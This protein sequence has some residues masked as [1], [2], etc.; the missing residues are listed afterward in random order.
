MKT[1][2]IGATGNVGSKVVQGLVA[3]GVNVR[4]MTRNADKAKGTMPGNVEIMTGDLTDPMTA[5]ACFEGCDAVFMLNPVAM[6][7]C[8]EGL[9]GVCLAQAAGVKK[10]VYM[11]VQH[12]SVAP[13]IPHFG[14]KAAI[15]LAIKNSGMK[16]TILQ[17]NNFFQNDY[18]VKDAV[19]QMSVYPQPIGDVGCHR[20]DAR[21]IA[22]A[23]VNAL[24]KTNFENKA[25]VLCGPKPI[26]GASCA[27]MWST[28]LGKKIAYAGNDLDQW[29]KAM[30]SMLPSW[31]VF[32]FG[33]MYA[34]FQKSGLKATDAEVKACEEI[35]GHPLRT[36]EAFVTETC[37]AWKA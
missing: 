13:H 30:S 4:V 15:E 2:V 18:W 7:E 20:V 8:Q 11:G 3:K 32:D 9:A 33:V 29:G 25:Y 34:H 24:T 22:D 36:F 37:A 21:D 1:L 23:A 6:T 26:N 19:M 28:G 31:M 5:K 12:A 10:F 35:V 16:W 27:E 14:S 17:P